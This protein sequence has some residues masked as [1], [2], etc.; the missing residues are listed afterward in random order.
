M[1]STVRRKRQCDADVA[2]AGARDAAGENRGSA[3]A[4]DQPECADEFGDGFFDQ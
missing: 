2:D 3:A 4:K 1:V